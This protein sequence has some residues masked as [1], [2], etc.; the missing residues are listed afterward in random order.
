MKIM[1]SILSVCFLAI[2]AVSITGCG[3]TANQ[4]DVLTAQ[5]GQISTDQSFQGSKETLGWESETSIMRVEN[6]NTVDGSVYVDHSIAY[7]TGW[8]IPGARLVRGIGQGIIGGVS[9]AFTVPTGVGIYRDRC[10]PVNGSVYVVG[11]GWGNGYD[12]RYNNN[13]SDGTYYRQGVTVSSGGVNYDYNG[14]VTGRSGGV[15]YRY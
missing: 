12:N 10:R 5:A 8:H 13:C 4:R 2:M 6:T 9:A 14:C 11:G 15:N 3:T 7:S 1:Q